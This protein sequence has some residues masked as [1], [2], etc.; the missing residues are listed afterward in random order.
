MQL[1]EGGLTASKPGDV[2]KAAASLITE[3]ATTE[4]V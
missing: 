1:V 2:S 3:M 4:Q